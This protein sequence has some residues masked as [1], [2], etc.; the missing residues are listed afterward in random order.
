[1]LSTDP[2]VFSPTLNT[3]HQADD[4]NSCMSGVL[5]IE[6]PCF[7]ENLLPSF[8][9]VVSSPVS[10]SWK[11]MSLKCSSCCFPDCHF[12]IVILMRSFGHQN[13]MELINST[14]SP[15][16]ESHFFQS[17]SAIDCRMNSRDRGRDQTGWNT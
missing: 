9:I 10:F 11:C 6:L 2:P 13:I 4:S 3:S 1:M 7:L 14:S 8:S 15:T 17:T 5:Q 16:L 12:I